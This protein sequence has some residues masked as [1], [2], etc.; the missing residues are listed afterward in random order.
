M[1]VYVQR[2]THTQCNEAVFCRM[3]SECMCMYRDK[4]NAKRKYCERY[5]LYV[6]MSGYRWV[7]LTTTLIM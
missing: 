5:L 3:F 1:Y 4:L 7:L 2:D 6:R